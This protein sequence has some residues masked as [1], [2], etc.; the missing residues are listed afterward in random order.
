[1]TY[2]V[3]GE[4]SKTQKR[5]KRWLYQHPQS[6]HI[7]LTVLTSVNVEYLVGQVRAGAQMLHIV[8]CHADCL[9]PELFETFCRPFLTKLARDVKRRLHQ[10]NL[11]P[12][13]MVR[14][15]EAA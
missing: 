10:E 11:N 12:V 14:R 4:D 9:G 13:P 1:M 8:E 6:S 2:I 7:L 15:P 3:E 5:A